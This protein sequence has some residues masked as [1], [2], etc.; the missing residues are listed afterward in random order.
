[1]GHFPEGPMNLTTHFISPSLERFEIFCL[2]LDFAEVAFELL[3]CE[4]ILHI[5]GG[6]RVLCFESVSFPSI[7]VISKPFISF[8]SFPSHSYG[9]L[10]FLAFHTQVNMQCIAIQTLRGNVLKWIGAKVQVKLAIVIFHA[11]C[12][13]HICHVDCIVLVSRPLQFYTWYKYHTRKF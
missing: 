3:T 7:C 8:T 13:V 12:T 10:I 4:I 11:S 1:M 6:C 9:Y 5:S 2:A